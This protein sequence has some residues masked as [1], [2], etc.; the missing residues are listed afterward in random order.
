MTRVRWAV[1]AAAAVL[2][3][4]SGCVSCDM[5]TARASWEA[6]PSCEVPACDR[7][8]VY[9]VLV[10][11][12]CPAGSTSL[13]G[14]RDGLAPRGFTKVYFGQILHAYWLASEM[15][16]VAKCNP[17]A[18]FIVVGADIGCPIAAHLTRQAVADG[19]TVDALVLLEPVG[20]PADAGCA[21]RTVLVSCGNNGSAPHT[22]RAAISGATR[23]TLPGHPGTVDL[24]YDLMKESAARVEHPP[25][26]FDVLTDPEG[27]QPRDVTPPPGA[28]PE[29]LF[30]HDHPGFSPAPLSPLPSNPNVGPIAPALVPRGGYQ[31]PERLPRPQVMPP[32][33]VPRPQPAPSAPPA[34]GQPLPVPRKIEQTP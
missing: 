29:W 15:R 17:S 2:V 14:L 18:R 22:E 8:N 21:T 4:G 25:G 26:L 34:N 5:R 11:G 20:V 31:P 27:R 6:G 13:E 33:I 3:G 30:L 23:F 28:A 1:A 19:V 32:T 7:S 9:A 10:N 16:A 12:A 24:V